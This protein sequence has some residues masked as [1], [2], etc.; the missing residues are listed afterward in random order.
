KD[1]VVG[2][3]EKRETFIDGFE[4]LGEVA[5]GPLGGAV[6][7]VKLF[8][9]RFQVARA[10][11]HPVFQHGC[12][13]KLLKGISPVTGTL[14]DVSHECVDDVEEFFEISRF[15]IGRVEQSFGW[16]VN[17]SLP[18]MTVPGG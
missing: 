10:L 9:R 4:R 17:G 12:A 7:V 6:G 5:S 3:I 11:S 18:E 2:G 1:E 13:A 8:Q 14:F 16:T 15:A